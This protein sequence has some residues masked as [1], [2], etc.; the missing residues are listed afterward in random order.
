MLFSLFSLSVLFLLTNVKSECYESP[1]TLFFS[2][3]EAFLLPLKLAILNELTVLLCFG[4][5]VV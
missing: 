3:Q 1:S 4:K 2:L 5:S